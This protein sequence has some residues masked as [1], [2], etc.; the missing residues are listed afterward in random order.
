MKW[1]EKNWF[2]PCRSKKEWNRVKKDGL[3]DINVRKEVEGNE[4]E[5]ERIERNEKKWRGMEG[6]RRKRM[7]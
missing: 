5:K 4:R 7:N 2:F 1:R 6:S 3:I